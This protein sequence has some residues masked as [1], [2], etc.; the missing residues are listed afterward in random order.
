MTK[1]SAKVKVIGKQPQGGI[2]LASI[3]KTITGTKVAFPHRHSATID[4]GI[5]VKV[6]K[7][8]KLCFSISPDL[9]AKGMIATNAPGHLTE[10][11]VA[12]H[13]LNVGREIVEVKDGDPVAVCWVEPIHDF[14]W[15]QE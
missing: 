3:P 9:A 10:G 7:G 12:L 4:T 2:L 1:K 5:T 14:E 11:R 13:L 8:W 6:E 15:E